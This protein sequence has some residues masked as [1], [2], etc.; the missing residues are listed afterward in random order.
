MVLQ[1]VTVRPVPIDF[2]TTEYRMVAKVMVSSS[3]LI[4]VIN[5]PNSS[6][7]EL[8]DVQ[9][10]LTADPS[11]LIC[12][13]DRAALA[14]NQILAACAIRRDHLGN[15][16]IVHSGY[17]TFER[18]P[19]YFSFDRYEV[20]ATLEWTGRLEPAMVLSETQREFIP[21]FDATLTSVLSARVCVESPA[22]LV[23]RRKI[24]LV[25]L[26]PVK[27]PETTLKK[28]GD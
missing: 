9:M 16:A 3:G 19:V 13:Y 27:N 4:G 5:D 11:Q 10:A 26:N 2:I 23:N 24:E 14:K 6:I 8:H 1:S 15:T 28:A 25:A 12:H 17:S 22:V 18:Y 21:V 20:H 7:I